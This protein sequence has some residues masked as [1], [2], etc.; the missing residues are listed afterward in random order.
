LRT[1]E[2]L[3]RFYQNVRLTE[4]AGFGDDRN[5]IERAALQD[6]PRHTWRYLA[7]NLNSTDLQGAAD[8]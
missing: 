3:S 4:C 1:C 8:K 6:S 2:E 7:F 5:A